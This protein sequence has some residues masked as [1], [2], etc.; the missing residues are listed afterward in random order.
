MKSWQ[1]DRRKAKAAPNNC[2]KIRQLCLAVADDEAGEV[3]GSRLW[4]SSSPPPGLISPPAR[5]I[6]RK[7]EM[8]GS[9]NSG[10]KAVMEEAS[11]PLEPRMQLCRFP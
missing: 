4:N 3:G 11:N 5:G 8:K 7:A 1:W 6:V 9:R 2:S 10:T